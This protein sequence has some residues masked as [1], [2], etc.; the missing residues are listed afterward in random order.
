LQPFETNIQQKLANFSQKLGTINNTLKPTLA[1]KFSRIKVYNTLA[2]P[3]L[4]YGRE[5]WNLEKKIKND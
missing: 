4:L 1:H 3:K 2:L 5:I